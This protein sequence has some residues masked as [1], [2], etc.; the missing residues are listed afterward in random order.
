M[1][2]KMKKVREALL[3]MSSNTYVFSLNLRL[4]SWKARVVLIAQHFKN[5]VS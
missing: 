3:N 1:G 2:T 4:K 5:Q